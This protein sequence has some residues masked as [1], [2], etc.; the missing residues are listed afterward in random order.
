M[1]QFEY[2][3][4][5]NIFINEDI[6]NCQSYNN[7][8]IAIIAEP[9][10]IFP[11]AYEHIINNINNIVNKFEYIFIP[12]KRLHNIHPNV[13]WASTIGT[14]WIET[15][16]IYNKTKLVSMIAS[17]KDWIEGHQLRYELANSLGNKVDG[18]GK[19]FN[20]HIKY[21][22]D[23]LNDYMFSICVE[24]SKVPGYFTEK[25]MDCF[26]TGTIPVY[27]GDP[28]I[29]EYFNINGIILLDESFDVSSL[30]PELYYSKMEYIK[31]NFEIAQ[32]YTEVNKFWKKRYYS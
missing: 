12:D 16:Q 25:I 9:P 29:G 27:W 7:K 2:N 13:V 24:N 3:D 1:T 10:G 14:T 30:T 18:Y 20:N 19:L 26:N 15:P 4:S 31:E 17:K 28:D 6:F 23:A 11:V 5:W 22:G 21:K 32:T 8:N